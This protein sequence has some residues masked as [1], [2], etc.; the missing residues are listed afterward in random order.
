VDPAASTGD[1]P[2]AGV[3]GAAELLAQGRLAE[4]EASCRDILKRDPLDVSAMCLLAD[5]GLR[6]G[7]LS[8]VEKLLDRCLEL[9]PDYHL[10]RGHLAHFLFKGHRFD[11]ALAELDRIDAAGAG[12][13]AL[14]LL[15]AQLY[16][17]VGRTK[18]ALALYREA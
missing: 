4:A 7:A 16:V 17:R 15:R 10:A 13:I 8:D 2:R 18:E 11:E 3:L 6:M 12:N 1:Q 14:L 9:A 5:I